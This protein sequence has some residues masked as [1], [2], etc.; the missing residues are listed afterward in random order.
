MRIHS[1]VPGV[2]FVSAGSLR[3]KRP[4]NHDVGMHLPLRKAFTY[5]ANVSVQFLNGMVQFLAIPEQRSF[6][7]SR[8]SEV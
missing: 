6:V 7:I 3:A 8:G 4:L 5:A 1:N 2:M